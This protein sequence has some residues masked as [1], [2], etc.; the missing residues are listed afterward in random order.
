[1]GGGAD[2]R[3]D[4]LRIQGLRSLVDVRLTPGPALNA[5]V[6]PN[7]AG[8][9]SLLEA[10]FLF[11]HGRSFRSGAR[12]ALLGRHADALHLFSVWQAGGEVRRLG[13][14]REGPRWQARRDG[15]GITLGEL[16]RQCAVVSFDPGSHA[17]I[18]A[19]AEERRRFLDWGVFHVEQDFLPAWQ[20]YQR[21][22]KQRNRLLRDGSRDD[23]LY[24]IWER[25]L[26]ENAAAM[27]AWREA[28]MG[29]WLPVVASYA[30]Q[31]LPELGEVSLR[32]RQGWAEG[33]ALDDVLRESRSRDMGRGH[34]GHGPHRADW[35][36][37]YEGA[38]QREH[39]SRGQEKL[40]AVACLLGQAS[41][42]HA[43]RGEWPVVCVDDLASELDAGHQ[44][45]LLA[46]LS[47]VGAQV[48]VTGTALPRGLPQGTPVFHVEQGQVTPLL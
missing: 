46:Q 4:E 32:F 6:G 11:S 13:L 22:L 34:T 26:A 38:P 39:L 14:G 35:S 45:A 27:T 36:V 24:E 17:L 7:G 21:A 29:S 15:E 33:S 23:A 5:F 43:Q 2:V 42:Y 18:A 47:Q 31:L 25:E 19:G 44:D 48:W 20:R 3:I 1:M 41:L 12:D 28:Y 10:V 8:K 9:T 37:S 16:V 30:A 40:T